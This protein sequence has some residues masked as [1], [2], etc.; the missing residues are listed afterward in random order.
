MIKDT[1]GPVFPAPVS[2]D[3]EGRI[4]PADFHHGT[5]GGLDLAD[6]AAVKIVA[7]LADRIMH[8]QAVEDSL[9]AAG[10]DTDDFEAYTAHVAYGFAD[11]LVAE[12][13]RR[14]AG[15]AD[16]FRP[17]ASPPKGEP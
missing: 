16:G 12:K 13:R 1:G 2:T 9:H 3:H 4:L 15:T 5:A 11:A 6:Y 10:I 8:D 14:E 7:A 17:T